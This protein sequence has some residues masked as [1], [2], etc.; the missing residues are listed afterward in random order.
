[1][2]DWNF[3]RQIDVFNPHE[4]RKTVHVVGVGA[5]GS[6]LVE[7]LIRT[8][9]DN[10]HVYDMD[11]VDDHNVPNQAF[12]QKHIGQKKVVAM[13]E[14]AKELGAEITPH[15]GKVEALDLKEPSYLFAAVD[16]MATRR[17]LFEAVTYNPNVRWIEAR[18]GAEHGYIYAINPIRPEEIEFWNAE[19]ISDDEAE[20]PA[21]TNRAVA[22]TARIIASLMAH[23]LIVWEASERR[24]DVDRPPTRQMV[25]LRPFM[26]TTKTIR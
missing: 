19:W 4:F 5:I 18:M 25:S 20:L 8:G 2:R 24:E 22:T 6:H 26:L 12:R 23:E 1:M 21:C 13:Q 15:D 9:I 14:L 3:W 16:S 7:T 10:I 17:S 11:E